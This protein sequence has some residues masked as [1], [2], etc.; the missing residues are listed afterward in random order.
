MTTQITTAARR[1]VRETR[2]ASASMRLRFD[3]DGNL[4][5]SREIGTW[6]TTPQG[7]EASVA[8]VTTS[9]RWK[10]EAPITQRQAQ[11][12]LDASATYPGDECNWS[13]QEWIGYELQRLEAERELKAQW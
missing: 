7:W 8:V 12:M 11:D 2:S 9:P 5:D 3:A 4:L 1:I 13:R 6:Y 10:H